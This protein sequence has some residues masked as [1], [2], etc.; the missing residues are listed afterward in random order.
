LLANATPPAQATSSVTEAWCSSSPARLGSL[1]AGRL[2]ALDP[3]RGQGRGAR[4][5]LELERRPA[6]R[7]VDRDAGIRHLLVAD[8]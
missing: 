4:V 2:S 8:E 5:D 1:A 7:C 3:A 6:G